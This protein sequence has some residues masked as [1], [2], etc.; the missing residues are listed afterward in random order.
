MGAILVGVYVAH[1]L[2]VFG[3]F[4]LAS[5]SFLNGPPFQELPKLLPKLRFDQNSKFS[6]GGL[7]RE[8]RI[9]MGLPR[10]VQELWREGRTLQRTSS[11]S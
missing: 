11:T 3:Y 7:S 6:F 8:V 4:D 9:Q 1:L 5:D 10:E 2:P